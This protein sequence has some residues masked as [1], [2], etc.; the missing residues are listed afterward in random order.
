MLDSMNSITATA[1]QSVGGSAAA[2]D[3]AMLKMSQD[4]AKDQA[5]QLLEA[6]PP[7]AQS[8]SPQGVGGKID[9]TA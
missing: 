1:T 8:P 7:P 6:L 4:V 9:L 2:E 5:A 3:M